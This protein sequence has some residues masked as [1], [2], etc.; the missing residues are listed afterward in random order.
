MG[1]KEMVKM[2]T[3]MGKKRTSFRCP[4][5]VCCFVAV[6]QVSAFLVFFGSSS[7]TFVFERESGNGH[8]NDSII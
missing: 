7:S 3:M 6:V 5:V 4:V 8:C 1:S 2:G